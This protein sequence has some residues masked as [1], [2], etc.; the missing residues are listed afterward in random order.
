MNKYLKLLGC[1]ILVN[2]P[3]PLHSAGPEDSVVKVFASIRFPNPSQPWVKGVANQNFGS[4]VVIKGNRIL[5]N[6]HVVEYGTDIFVQARPGGDKVEAKIEALNYDVDLAI[7]SV[8]DDK[9]FQKRPPLARQ[10]LLPK[11]QNTVAVYGFPIGGNDLSI[12]KGEVSRIDSFNYGYRGIGL[13]IQVSA[14]INPGNSG[15]PALVGDKMV[16]LVVSRAQNAQNIGYVIPNEEI[17][18]F[19]NGLKDNHFEGKPMIAPGLSVQ[20]LEN[21]ALRRRFKVEPSVRGLLV[22][23]ATIEASP[24]LKPNDVIKSIGTHPIDNTG[25]VQLDNGVQAFYLYLVP[26]LAQDERVP[27]TVWRQG[28]EFEASLPVTTKD[29]R[30]LRPYEGEPLSYFIHGPLV[31]AVAKSDD[32]SLYAQMNRTL[33]LDNGPLVTRREDFVRFPGEELVVVSARMFV[34][35]I[36]KGYAEP[37]GRV[38]KDVNGTAIKSLRHLV[39]TM[40]D[41]TDEFLTI[42]FFDNWSETMVFDRKEMVKATDDILEDNGISP[43]RRGSPELLKIWKQK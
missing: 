13:I 10:K 14:S 34:H 38:V 4:G 6:A 31:F 2:V 7:L 1:F 32:I 43:N 39:E 21:E 25:M 36:S 37:V 26:R 30:L 33:Y 5:T 24:R 27:V 12:T 3:A 28:R 42:R 11:I 15:G 16:G 29:N 8:K 19:L 17:E 18:I 41:S 22:Q 40:R 35:P 23:S 20:V 9:F